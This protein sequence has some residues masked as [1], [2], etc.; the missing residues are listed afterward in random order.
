MNGLIGTFQKNEARDKIFKKFI[1]SRLNISVSNRLKSIDRQEM[2]S[3]EQSNRRKHSILRRNC[4][5]I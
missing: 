4:Q 3:K 5:R 1:S 2:T